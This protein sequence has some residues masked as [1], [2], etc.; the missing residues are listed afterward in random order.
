MPRIIIV[1]GGICGLQL[2]ALLSSD[3]CEV[4]VLEKLSRLGGRAFI[5]EKEGFS[6]DHGIHLIRF[7]PK[8]AIS[9][10][11]R[12]LNKPLA[13]NAL[14]TSYVRFPNGKVVDFPT[15]PKGFLTTKMMT[16]G[17]R[18][19][20]IRLMIKLRSQDFTSLFDTSVK[21]WMDEQGYGGGLRNYLSLVSASMQV[22]PNIERSSA[23]EM[24]MNMQNVILKGYSTMYPVQGW[25]YIYTTLI[26]AIKEKGE[27]RTGTGVKSVIV[28]NGRACGVELESG[29][30]LEADRV[31]VTLPAQEIFHVID[32]SL[33]PKDFS[34]LCK[35][36]RPTAGVTIDYGLKQRISN[37]DGL[38]YFWKPMSFGLFTSNIRPET[39]PPGK[40]LLTWFCPAEHSEMEDEKKV[41]DLEKQLEQTI[42]DQFKGLENAIEW[43]RAMH[44][45]MVDG[46]EINVDQHRGKRPGYLVPGIDELFLAGDS[47][48]GAGAGGDVGHESVL[49]CYREMTGRD[50]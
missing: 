42:F 46:V 14:G 19:K 50:I 24:L 23:G 47:L 12:R 35:G 13:Y 48:K 31:V 2:G 34:A 4:T 30:R 43:R 22:C 11:F 39:A 25:E 36:L 27:I 44:L 16:F 20:A 9:R 41:C 45:T 33:V 38:W 17:E 15:S 40:Q 5:L 21:D 37:D 10:V 49:G 7:G 28:E 1:G 6:V 32:E 3:G 8:S 18:L 26:E 29:D